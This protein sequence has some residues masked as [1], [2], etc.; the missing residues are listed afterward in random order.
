MADRQF[1]SDDDETL[2]DISD[3]GNSESDLDEDSDADYVS[4]GNGSD[5]ETFEDDSCPSTPKRS[6]VLGNARF[7]TSASNNNWRDITLKVENGT[8]GQQF[9]YGSDSE[10]SEAILT[11]STPKRA[12][13]IGNGSDSEVSETISTPCTLSATPNRARKGRPRRTLVDNATSKYT[14]WYDVTSNDE[15]GPETPFHFRAK[16]CGGKDLPEANSKPIEYFKLFFT[17]ELV[18]MIVNETNKYANE[19]IQA[20]PLSPKSRLH[21]WKNVTVPEMYLVIGL[22]L[23]TGIVKMPCL[24]DYWSTRPELHMEYFPKAIPRSRFQA[25]FHTM[26]HCCEIEEDKRVKGDG[27]Q[28]IID[29]IVNKFQKHFIPYQQLAAVETMITYKGSIQFRQYN[30]RKPIKLGLL[31][32]TLVDANTGYMLNIIMYYGKEGGKETIPNLNKTSSTIVELLKPYLHKGYHVFCDRLYTSLDLADHLH[33]ERTYLTGSIMANRIG[34]PVGISANQ[35]K[36]KSMR[37]GKILLQSWVNKRPV[38]MISTFYRGDQT[39]KQKIEKC[40]RTFEKPLLIENYNRYLGGVDLSDQYTSYYNCSR[41]SVPWW[42]KTFFWLLEN[43]VTNSYLLYKR[44]KPKKQ[45]K[46]LSSLKFRQDLVPDLVDLGREDS[47]RR[48]QISTASAPGLEP[49][50]VCF[51][52]QKKVEPGRRRRECKF[53]SRR[54]DGMRK[55]TTF[56]CDT[57]QGKPGLHPGDCF[58]LYHLQD[59]HQ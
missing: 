15:N 13:Y 2:D 39:V 45:R 25:I 16:G 33:N 31:A 17:E 47:Q 8:D 34:I 37:S 6:R 44:S 26:L 28:P 4:V 18:G 42:K 5:L 30:P 1:F 21:D 40:N 41:K 38:T 14:N 27:I 3:L 11:C 55:D 50:S 54:T 9:G 53:C 52:V 36:I 7:S 35:R 58:S 46:Y 12:R 51:H 32:Q 49:T 22:L 43:C 56:Y 23:N 29:Y 20:T 24:S 48:R 57:C 59:E 19:K 10:E